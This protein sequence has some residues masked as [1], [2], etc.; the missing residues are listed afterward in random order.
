MAVRLIVPTDDNLIAYK[1]ASLNFGLYACP[2]YVAS[3]GPLAENWTEQIEVLAYNDAYGAIG[4]LA[5][6]QKVGLSQRVVASTS[7]TRGLIE[8]AIGG[9]GVAL[10]PEFLALKRGLAELSPFEQLKMPKREVWLVWHK[11]MSTHPPI[12]RVVDWV[13]DAFRSAFAASHR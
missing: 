11:S 7:S 1:L 13:K 5:W 10:L 9:A 4:E 6:L 12:R 2:S 3:L 8:A